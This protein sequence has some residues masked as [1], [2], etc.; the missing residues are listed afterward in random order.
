[1]KTPARV[2]KIVEEAVYE[3]VERQVLVKPA[4]LDS[5][6]HQPKTDTITLS[7]EGQLVKGIIEE[8]PAVEESCEKVLCVEPEITT[9]DHKPEYKTVTKIEIKEGGFSKWEEVL[10]PADLDSYTIGLIQQALY[11]KG[12]DPGPADNL[13]GDQ[14]KVALTRYQKENGLPVG[15]LNLKTLK[16]LGIKE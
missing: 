9:L 5:I 13:I 4:G 7:F 16:S 12:Y 14:T 2:E 8:E 3:I 10:C 11:T 6:Y 1:M 15:Q